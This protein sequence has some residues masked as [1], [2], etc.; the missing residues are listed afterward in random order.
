MNHDPLCSWNPKNDATELDF[1]DCDLIARVREDERSNYWEC[2]RCGLQMHRSHMIDNGPDY[3]GDPKYVCPECDNTIRAA[4]LRDAAEA[5]KALPW[6]RPWG[7]DDPWKYLR[8]D[9]AVAAIE[10]LG[11][12]R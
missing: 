10:G 7:D 9:D 1:C 12:E 6:H 3:K 2:E 8:R 4:A 11:G 5:V